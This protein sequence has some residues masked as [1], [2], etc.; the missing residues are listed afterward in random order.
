M[1]GNSL[2]QFTL[3]NLGWI[4]A[5]LLLALVVWLAATMSNNPV[6][7]RE[8]DRV[9]IAIQ[10]PDGY[11]LT[12]QVTTTM[13]EVVL[14]A[15][16]S[17]WDL[18]VTD[19]VRVTAALRDIDGPGEYRVEL[20]AR[21][22]SPRRGNVAA[23]RPSTLTLA[24]D[25]EAEKLVPV[26]VTVAKEPPLGYTYP[27]DLVCSQTEVTVRGS[28]EKVESVIAAEVRL[29]LSDDLNPVVKEDQPLIPVQDDGREVKGAIVLEPETVDCEVEIQARED[30]IQVRVL[31]NVVGDPPE[32]YIFD[33]RVDVEPETVGV[34]G[35]R[36]VINQLTSGLV[37]TRPIVLTGHTATF[38]TEIELD[39]PEGAMLVPEGQI[40][41]VT[42]TITSVPISR[43]FDGIPVEITGLD[44]IQFR[45]SGLPDTMTVVMV[46]PPD[47]LP[48]SEDLRVMVDLS[49]LPPG[50]HQVSPQGSLVSEEALSSAVT[51]SVLPEELSVTI[52][53]LNPTPTPSPTPTGSPDVQPTAGQSPQD[54]LPAG[55]PTATLVP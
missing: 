36:R 50:N 45:A 29:V 41:R 16:K 5:S 14:R 30:V 17:E 9:P 37:S 40:I 26:R 46:G 1:R 54:S 22:E 53:A 20:E 39:L 34:T 43:R 49:G 15:Q 6:E 7:Q 4:T 18:I 19:D 12:R 32:G 11:V 35:T 24:V 31:P 25:Q 47:A 8:L 23:I 51:I 52:E 27:S 55:E 38:T 48:A 42:V 44:S 13:A 10:L 33:G 28:R 3:H 2:P 21:V